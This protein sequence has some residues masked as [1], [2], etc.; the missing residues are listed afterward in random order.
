[1]ATSSALVC[2]PLASFPTSCARKAFLHSWLTSL[3][4]QLSKTPVEVLELSPPYVQTELTGAPP[5]A[6][7]RAMPIGD[8]IRQVMQMLERR[9]HPRGEILLERDQPSRWAEREGT[10]AVRFAGLNPG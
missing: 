8:Y 4:H 9:N 1:M 3:R 5:I 2:V 10:Y 7:P 6:D